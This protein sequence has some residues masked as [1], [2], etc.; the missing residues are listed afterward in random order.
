MNPDRPSLLA[1]PSRLRA[2]RVAQ[3]GLVALRR[4]LRTAI[5]TVR[6]GRARFGG[7]GAAE[8]R[9]AFEDLGPTFVKFGQV[10]AS[11]PAFPPSLVTEF[12]RCLDR[13]T[14]EPVGIVRDTL[15]DA[16]GDV[17]NV[18]SEF[19]WN[20]IAAGS[21][22]QVFRAWGAD[23]EPLVVK[24]QRR[25]LE[26]IL[27]QDVRMMHLGGRALARL[28]PSARSVNPVGVVEDFAQSL[29]QELDFVAE[30][31]RMDELRTTFTAW[32]IRIP[33]VR[34]DLTAPTVL[35]MAYLDG[36]KISDVDGLDRLGVDRGKLVDTVYGS[37]ISTACRHGMF[38]G[39]MHAGNIIV[40][41]DGHIGLIDFGIVGELPGQ[42][43][44]HVS[45]LLQCLFEQRWDRL[46]PLCFEMA[47]MTNVDMEGAIA[48]LT[49]VADKYL[50][51]PLNEMPLAEMATDILQRANK[52]GFVLP[53]DVLLFFKSLLYLDGLGIRIHPGYEVLNPEHGLSLLPFLAADTGG[54]P[55][56]VHPT[57]GYAHVLVDEAATA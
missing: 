2:G 15:V 41:P 10:I 26:A 46:A 7:I 3:I 53:T 24:V 27:R 5:R 13:V 39:D 57:Y 4:L 45:E 8:T 11:S 30:A 38:H 17:D 49:A 36:V 34:W 43:R 6:E 44:L 31:K 47:D 20:P 21:I 42:L 14:P 32:P 56:D 19:D 18:F 12:E 9:R 54:A 33:E 16:L 22:A 48:D 1:P 35:T 25:N 55:A 29:A 51:M 23:G 28:I 52:Y 37:L 50:A 40:Q